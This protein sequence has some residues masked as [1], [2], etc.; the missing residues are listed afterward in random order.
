A[1]WVT[2]GRRG[3]GKTTTLIM[4]MMAVTG[5][6]PAAAAWSSNEEERRKALLAYLLEG[7]PALIWD[8]IPHGTKIACP[9][10]EK[11][12][13]AAMYSDR[14]LGVSETIVA[15]AATIHLFTGNN[16]GP[17]RDLASRSLQARIEVDRPDPEN[18]YFRHPEPIEWTEAHRRQIL[19]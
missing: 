15:S 13:S 18:R 4:L 5:V 1:V 9:H 3:G 16:V 12:C 11:S 8:N 17:R 10:I 19:K 7:L 14:K 6:R 2:A